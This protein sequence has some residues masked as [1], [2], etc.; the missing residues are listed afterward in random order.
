MAKHSSSPPPLK[1]KREEIELDE[2]EQGFENTGLDPRLI[3]ALIKKGLKNPTPIQRVAIPLILGGNDVLARAKTGSGKTFAYLLPLL[4]KLLSGVQLKVAQ[5]NHDMSNIALKQALYGPP[6]VL[7]STP[8]CVQKCLSAGFLQP[9]A[10]HDSLSMLI[11]D[12]ADFLLSQG[13]EDDLRAFIGH[14]PRCC[15]CLLM[16]ATSRYDDNVEKLKKLFLHN[17]Y[18]LTLPEED[19]GKNEII[20]NHVDQFWFRIRA[21]ILN[22]ELPQNSR[23]HIIEEFNAGL[24]DYLIAIDDGKTNT[25]EQETA[26][27]DAEVKKSKKQRKQKLDAEFGVVRGIDFKNVYTVINFEMP[28]TTAG[29]RHRIGRTGRACNIGASVSLVSPNEMEAFEELKST[30]AEQR[31]GEGDLIEPFPLLIKNVAESLRYRAEDQARSVTEAV[32]VKARAQDIRNEILNSEKLT[33]HFL[34]NN[35]RDLDLLK[36]DKVLSKK[37]APAYLGGVPEYLL[38][39]TTQEA[40]K[41]MKHNQAAL[42]NEKPDRC[43]NRKKRF[44]K[45]KD[46]LKAISTE[47]DLP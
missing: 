34:A 13:Y 46:P 1:R 27:K 28:A 5:L 36:H 21:A 15:Q 17:P 18:I 6:D 2:E 9:K 16:S 12:E 26:G 40:S 32:I 47:V 24:F 7:V 31:S 19:G 33:A 29:Y 45:N 41:I 23:L 43:Q 44:R 3:R 10:I 35:P 11:L 20:P 4:H 37:E 42:G 30:L 22:A 25:K 14:V 38:D 8:F 39:A